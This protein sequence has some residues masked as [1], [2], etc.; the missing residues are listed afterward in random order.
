MKKNINHL[1]RTAI[2]SAFTTASILIPLFT[3][4]EL[5]PLMKAQATMGLIG[6]GMS[7]GQATIAEFKATAMEQENEERIAALEAASNSLGFVDGL[8]NFANAFVGFI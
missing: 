4:M 7:L 3:A 5:T 2:S 1:F 6:V 8:F